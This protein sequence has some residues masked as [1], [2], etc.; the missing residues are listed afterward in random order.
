MRKDD[1]ASLS[2]TDS[3]GGEIRIFQIHGGG[4]RETILS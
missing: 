2:S 3:S 4:K 1:G